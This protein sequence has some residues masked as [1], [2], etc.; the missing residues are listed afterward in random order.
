FLSFSSCHAQPDISLGGK[1]HPDPNWKPIIYL[2][3]PRHWNEIA[4]DF[5]GQVVDSAAIAQDGA[6]SF[7]PFTPDSERTLFILAIQR[8]GNRFPNHLTDE[9]PA[10][11]NYMPLIVKKGEHLKIKTALPDF[12]KTFQVEP[13]SV[14]NTTILNLRDIRIDAFEKFLAPAH[15]GEE[16]DSLLLEKE[17]AQMNFATPLMQFADT[18]RCLEAALLASR[19]ISPT[20]DYERMPEFITGQCRKW[21]KLKPGHAMVNELCAAANTEKL[22]L[23]IGDPFPDF[24]M[25]LNTGDS[26]RISNMLGKKLTLIDLWASWCAPCRKENLTI[27]VPLWQS[28]KSDGLQIIGYS[29]DANAAAWKNAIAKD[30]TSWIQA[31]HLRGDDSPFM[32][33]LHLT[34]IPANF[35]LDA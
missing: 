16:D 3:Q 14:E 10:M 27:L 1:I 35:I 24:S 15:S 7:K 33:E 32:D 4:G 13:L 20:G 8:K 29:L 17:K 34:T 19:W 5:L 9:D 26:V 31:S 18:T 21:E 2:I 12:Q 6:F 23:L 25:P 11:A 30:G 22:P 28:Y